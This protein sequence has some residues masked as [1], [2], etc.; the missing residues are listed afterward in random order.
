MEANGDQN[1]TRA[2]FTDLIV[3]ELKAFK[4]KA[5]LKV[6]A[7]GQACRKSWKI[8]HFSKR[9]LRIISLMEV[10]QKPKD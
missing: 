7:S 3:I 8:V 6:K 5:E 2:G 10:D 1:T 9:F 4:L